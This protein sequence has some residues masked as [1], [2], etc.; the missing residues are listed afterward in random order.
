MSEP[1]DWKDVAIELSREVDRLRRILLGLAEVLPPEYLTY[2]DTAFERT[3]GDFDSLNGWHETEMVKSD[4][5]TEL[6][7]LWQR[8][9]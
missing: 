9:T 6:E 4:V 2:L 8:L 1:A 7:A 3:P 5:I